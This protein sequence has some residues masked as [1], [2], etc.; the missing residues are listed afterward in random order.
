MGGEPGLI[1]RSGHEQEDWERLSDAISVALGK[2][3]FYTSDQHRRAIK[4]LPHHRDLACYERWASATERLLV[5][6]GIL[7]TLEIAE[8]AADLHRRWGN[9]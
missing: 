6:K 8:R 3:G 9:A 5:K 1:D 7:T 4:P 2:R